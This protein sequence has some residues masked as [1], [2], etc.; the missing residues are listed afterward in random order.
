LAE[1]QKNHDAYTELNTQVFALSTD[2]PEQSK[3]LIKKMN[4]PFTL[5]CDEDKKVIDLF[6]LRN[7]FEHEGIAYPGTF[8]INPEG[9][10]CYRSLDGTFNRVDLKDELTFL[11]QLHKDCG[12]T[13]E[14]GPK[15]SWILPSPKDNWRMAMNMLSQGNFADWKHFLLLP[16]SY[17]KIMGSKIKK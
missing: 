10:I 1:I 12:H 2:S 8:I 9:K 4:F 17:L 3:N 14:K 6:N 7:T 11:E 16:I 13:M 15:K 5:L